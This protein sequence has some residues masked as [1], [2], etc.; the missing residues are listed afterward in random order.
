MDVYTNKENFFNENK[1]VS[2][3][4][5]VNIDD[6]V[7]IKRTPEYSRL[8]NSIIQDKKFIFDDEQLKILNNSQQIYNIDNLPNTN[9]EDLNIS[10]ISDL[11]YNEC[12]NELDK[13]TEFFSNSTNFTNPTNLD[14]KISADKEYNKIL[15]QYKTDILNTIDPT[16]DNIGVLKNNI[17]F[18]KNYLKNYYKDIYGNQ[19]QADLADYFSAYYT[20]INNDDNIGFPVNTLIG[21][22]NFIIPDQYNYE[23][24]LTNAYNIDWNRVINPITLS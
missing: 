8:I 18:A 17:P 6:M 12:S 13:N 15:N 19:I 2:K 20:L 16:C 11:F 23:K 5:N 21:K 1:C 4:N 14:I 24:Y 3:L 7:I 10:N 22:S 9:I